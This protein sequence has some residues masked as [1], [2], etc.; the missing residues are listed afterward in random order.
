MT[1]KSDGVELAEPVLATQVWRPGSRVARLRASRSYWIVL[2]LFVATFVFIA[3]APNEPWALGVLAILQ[4]ATLFAALWTSGLGEDKRPAIPLLIGVGVVAV[5]VIA[6]ES[7]STA[8]LVAMVSALLVV[9]TM[10]AMVLGVVDQR[11]VNAQSVMGALCVY[12]LI[13]LF[14]TFVYAAIAAVHDDAFFASGETGSPFE[15]MYFSYV[16]LATLGYGDYTAA[17]TLGRSLA[18]AELLIGQLF[19][20]TA[21]GLL[22]GTLVA[23][24]GSANDDGR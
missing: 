9:A 20:V 5:L 3:A 22:I 19:L 23:R 8:A 12:L 7:D 16:T 18:V 14:F 17:E 21:V 13:G 2:V 11:E 1:T 4:G 10:A 6:Y 24:R 15:F